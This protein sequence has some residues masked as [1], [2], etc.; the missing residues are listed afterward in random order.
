VV[1][2]L[3]S[4]SDAGVGVVR[5]RAVRI[6]DGGYAQ[7]KLT[8]LVIPL[9]AGTPASRVTLQFPAGLARIKEV[10]LFEP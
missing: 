7:L 10:S 6:R 3:V 9:D 5:K 2:I 1:A 4:A 8:Y